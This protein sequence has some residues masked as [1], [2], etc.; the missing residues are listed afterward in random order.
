MHFD[1]P[2]VAAC[3]SDNR[4]DVGALFDILGTLQDVDVPNAKIRI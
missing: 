1:S 4:R 3:L 2:P